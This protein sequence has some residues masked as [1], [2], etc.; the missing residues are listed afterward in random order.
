MVCSLFRG[1]RIRVR[2]YGLSIKLT[3]HPA[4]RAD[5]SLRER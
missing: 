4:L 1:E 3:P 2:A 5:F